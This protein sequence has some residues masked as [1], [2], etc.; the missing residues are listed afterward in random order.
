MNTVNESSQSTG[1]ESRGSQISKLKHGR[2]RKLNDE[3]IA[4]A[5]TMYESGRSVA[6]IA[7]QF[8]VS[9]QSMWGSLKRVGTRMRSHKRYGKENHFYRGGARAK[10]KAQRKVCQALKT[11][12]LVA[13]DT[14]EN[15]G[16]KPVP[17][18]DGRR[19]IQAHHSDYDKPLQVRWLCQPCH[20]QEHKNA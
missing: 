11:G 12:S 17:F 16:Q 19:A 7:R 9:R 14:C 15:C 6:Q 4:S 8:G 10:R 13:P 18:R 5:R 20:H 1:L 3:V 2:Y